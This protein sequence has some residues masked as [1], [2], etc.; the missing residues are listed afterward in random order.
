MN[1][2]EPF[3]AGCRESTGCSLFRNVKALF[4]DV[5]NSVLIGKRKIF[6]GKID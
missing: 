1:C 6:S 3:L 4:L 2:C 5:I